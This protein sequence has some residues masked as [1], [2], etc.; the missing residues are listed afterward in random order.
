MREIARSRHKRLRALE[1]WEMPSIRDDR[2]DHV[3]A[4]RCYRRPCGGHIRRYE[5]IAISV[6]EQTVR[7]TRLSALS[8]FRRVCATST[9][10]SSAKFSGAAWEEGCLRPLGVTYCSSPMNEDD[11]PGLQARRHG[12]MVRSGRREGRTVT[13]QI[14]LLLLALVA[15]RSMASSGTAAPSVPD[16]YNKPSYGHGEARWK[17]RRR[18]SNWEA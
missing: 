9:S 14:R 4:P 7:L 5:G 10:S 18:T 17:S 15:L 11:R 8:R 16:E 6:Y 3:A 12:E 1:P 2:D 13:V